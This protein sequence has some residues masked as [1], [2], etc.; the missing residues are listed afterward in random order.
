MTDWSGIAVIAPEWTTGAARLV[1]RGREMANSLG[2][3]L[4]VV[5]G[6]E[7]VAAAGESGAD[8]VLTSD[9]ICAGHLE[10]W[11]RTAAPEALLFDDTP[12]AARI[13]GRLAGMLEAPIQE[14]IVSIDFDLNERVLL[15][16][17]ETYGGRQLEE[18]AA[19]PDAKPVIALVRTDR[20]P[21]PIPGYAR[22]PEIRA[23]P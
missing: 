18:W 11:I 19:P 8:E 7:N 13:A 21:D 17:L 4:R 14:G 23:L 12:G 2:C 9:N 20:L 15:M 22:E 1:S 16:R 3:Y 10:P 6:A 5:T